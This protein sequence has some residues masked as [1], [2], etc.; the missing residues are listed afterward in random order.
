MSANAAKDFDSNPLVTGFDEN[1]GIE[2]PI[3]SYKSITINLE[4]YIEDGTTEP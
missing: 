3:G 1:L 4:E 2:E